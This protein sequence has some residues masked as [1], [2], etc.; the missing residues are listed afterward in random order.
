MH[1]VS[2]IPNCQYIWKPLPI[3]HEN[4]DFS[5]IMIDSFQIECGGV[6]KQNYKNN[7]GAIQVWFIKFN[8]LL[9]SRL[10]VRIAIVC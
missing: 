5:Q 4:L 2:V 1:K 6:Q 3:K 9:I 8:Q 7:I 10:C